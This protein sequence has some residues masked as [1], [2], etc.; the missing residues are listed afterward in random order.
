MKITNG[1]FEIKETANQ[2]TLTVVLNDGEAVV[3]LIGKMTLQMVRDALKATG[4]YTDEAD[5]WADADWCKSIL[6]KEKAMTVA[7]NN[8]TPPIG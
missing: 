6:N 8:E 2:N 3:E 4:L 5:M 1:K 7:N